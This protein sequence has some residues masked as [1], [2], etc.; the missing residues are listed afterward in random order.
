M[1]PLF[2]TICSSTRIKHVSTKI[3]TFELIIISLTFLFWSFRFFTFT[4]KF[5]KKEHYF[6]SCCSVRSK[7]HL[8]WPKLLQMKHA[9]HALI[10]KDNSHITVLQI[11]QTK[12]CKTA[13]IRSCKVSIRSQRGISTRKWTFTGNN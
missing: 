9:K 6:T 12:F 5:N 7:F 13:R 3:L 1:A 4:L 11:F 8:C 10:F 2:F